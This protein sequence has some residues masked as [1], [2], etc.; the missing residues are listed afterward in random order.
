MARRF[1]E[2][3]RRSREHAAERGFGVV[4]FL[5]LVSV[6][7]LLMAGLAE[8][9][10]LGLAR[11]RFGAEHE[12]ARYLALA[13]AEH[14]VWRAHHEACFVEQNGGQDFSQAMGSGTYTYRVDGSRTHL[15]IEATGSAGRAT[16]RVRR[17]LLAPP[18]AVRAMVAYGLDDDEPLE[19]REYAG[20]AWQASAPTAVRA[21][22]ALWCV[23]RGCPRRRERL[24]AT[25]DVDKQIYLQRWD[26]VDWTAMAKLSGDGGATRCFDIAYENASGQALIVYATG[27][28]GDA[29]FRTW[30]GVTI[31]G[32][33]RLDLPFVG[34]VRWLALASRASSDEIALIAIDTNK[35]L[36]AA[37]WNGSSF[38][39][40]TVLDGNLL[41]DNYEAAAVA[42]LEPSGTAAFVWNAK[43][44]GVSTLRVALWRNA[45][46]LPLVPAL[47]M[48]EARFVRLV[49]SGSGD[50][51]RVGVLT[52][53]ADLSTVTVGLTGLGLP[54]ELIASNLATID[55]RCFDLGF[56]PSGESV[57]LFA[58]AGDGR[59]FIATSSG[60]LGWGSTSPGPN[61]DANLQAL[62]LRV[63][64]VTGLMH[65]GVGANSNSDGRTYL[66]LLAWSGAWTSPLADPPA[67][68]KDQ[69]E[70]FMLCVDG[71]VCG[72][73]VIAI[74]P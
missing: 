62:Q 58:R 38:G 23:L 64:R 7:A 61:L 37:M 30:N 34:T 48:D 12:R 40:V 19:A 56:L 43:L 52:K 74:G 72:P 24:L 53:N 51:A 28:D 17:A 66:Q 73:G 55:Q 32:D 33:Q 59:P 71:D 21:D 46:L 20:D 10:G 68:P 4:Y 70:P 5:V 69:G 3:R 9:G 22:R 14:A 60:A 67:T 44:L 41:T 15:T 13:G 16:H 29:H 42:F 1:P 8:L 45:W 31:S 2:T 11:S 65:I 6:A 57:A 27:N 18:Q 35:S 39:A 36:A 54:L 49:A 26:G 50:Q 25:L 63:D 47:P